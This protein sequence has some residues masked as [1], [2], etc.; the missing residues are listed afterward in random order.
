[1]PDATAGG[2][3]IRAEHPS[4]WTTVRRAL[5]VLVIDAIG[6][7][8]GAWLLSGVSISGFGALTAAVLIAIVNAIIWPTLSRLTLPLSALT[9]G[10]GNLVLSGAMIWLAGHISKGF[11]VDSIWWGIGLAFIVTLVNIAMSTLLGIDD[12]G[13]Y[14]QGVVRRAA[15]K[16]QARPTAVP[17]V[18]FLEIDGLAYEVMQRAMRNGHV[19]EFTRWLNGGTHRLIEWECDWSSQTGASQ[20]GLLHGHNDN[21]PAFRWFE[22]D[23]GLAMV[24]NHPR[25]TAVMQTRISDG[26]G[27]L[28][29]DGVSRANMFS[30]DAP[31]TL[32]TLS[33]I[34]VRGRGPIGR[35]YY[36]YFAN[37]FAVL[38]TVI[39]TA[40]DATREI[41]ASA[42]TRR[43]DIRPRVARGGLYPLVR[44][45]TTVIQRDLAAA[46]LIADI[47]A[48]RPVGYSTFV[49]YDEIAHHSGIERPETL[50]ALSQLDQQFARIVRA[51]E[52]APRPY[53]FVILSDH[54][55]TDGTCFRQ[56]HGE[57]LAEL[58]R[59]LTDDATIDAPSYDDE[60]WGMLSA[61]VSE[62]ASSP[63]AFGTAV[64]TTTR[65][66]GVD[67][68]VDLGPQAARARRKDKKA[69]GKSSVDGP[70]DMTVMASGCL[71]LI[72]LTDEPGRCTLE[73]ITE[74]HPRLIDGLRSHPGIGFLLVRRDDGHSVVL[75]AAGMHDLSTG[76]I[77]GND[78]LADY[79]ANAVSHVR[80]TDG[81]DHVGDIMV[82]ARFDPVRGE[83][84]AFEEFVGS[85]G[86]L[87]GSQ[88]Y[89]FALVPSEWHI[90]NERIVG[91]EVMHRQLIRWLEDLGQRADLSVPR[92]VEPAH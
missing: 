66:R 5:V 29:D 18:M 39:L 65:G 51:A 56:A 83:V 19:P 80:R 74:L 52:L 64:R 1:M 59:R 71:G 32:L 87:G 23:R 21:M 61:S 17:G 10:L 33:T 36:G 82:N 85:H 84:P 34:T 91:A 47:F 69:H 25:D 57:T 38:R 72:Y 31:H 62:A 8:I 79:G 44:A 54:G 92:P 75:G 41:W 90:P 45:W 70:S 55:Q 68:T 73:R 12:E 81:F 16:H 9:L 4:W 60:G 53:R 2:P 35:D 13:V 24:S 26:L 7:A 3:R 46:A 15:R 28:A 77:E 76:T 43:R 27:L 37:P 20:A 40:V 58:V 86:G 14:W 11:E 50:R 6:V 42:Q 48:G 22:K 30:G 88:S 67:G 78:P 63:T 89:P 49:G